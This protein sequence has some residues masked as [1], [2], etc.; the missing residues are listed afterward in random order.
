MRMRRECHCRRPPLP[1]A[2]DSSFRRQQMIQTN[3]S[4]H[5]S[6][7]TPD[8]RASFDSAASTTP[9]KSHTFSPQLNR[10]RTFSPREA[11]SSLRHHLPGHGSRS[12]RAS[13]YT[14]AGRLSTDGEEIPCPEQFASS[15][16]RNS[17]E[18]EQHRR[19]SSVAS[20]LV[21]SIRGLARRPTKSRARTSLEAA[22]P[23]EPAEDVPLPS[24]PINIPSAAPVLGLDLGQPGMNFMPAELASP[25]EHSRTDDALKLQDPANFA[26]DGVSGQKSSLPLVPDEVKMQYTHPAIRQRPVTPAEMLLQLPNESVR[27]SPPPTP[28]TPLPGT[29]LSMEMDGGSDAAS[30]GKKSQ[31]FERSVTP[32][33]EQDRKALRTMCSMDAIAEACSASPKNPAREIRAAVDEETSNQV[34]PSLSVSPNTKLFTPRLSIPS[35]STMSNCPSDMQELERQ[36][37][38]DSKVYDF[39][40]SISGK[41]TSSTTPQPIDDPFDDSNVASHGPPSPIR[42]VRLPLRLRIKGPSDESAASVEAHFS[43]TPVHDERDP[44]QYNH[45]SECF[46][47]S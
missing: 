32:T 36:A 46:T 19:R 21:G 2:L 40:A 41:Q 8:P 15:T 42:S 24:S 3:R 47:D 38:G 45:Y 28:T 5:F 6:S 9:L 22:R 34:S 23:G 17:D 43:P 33:T 18:I 29:N 11:V 30:S 10:R 13:F 37:S 7:S 4:P 14:I 35:A 44:E 16:G 12:K 27:P 31:V 20:S 1:F 26:I 39:G 25:T